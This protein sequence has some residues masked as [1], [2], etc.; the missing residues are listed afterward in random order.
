MS[1]FASR[2][3][4]TEHTAYAVTP[5][6]GGLLPSRAGLTGRPLGTATAAA[7]RRR[8]V[9]R[10]ATN[11]ATRREVRAP[12]PLPGGAGCQAAPGNGAAHTT[13]SGPLLRRGARRRPRRALGGLWRRLED[14]PVDVEPAGHAERH[15][16][17]HLRQRQPPP[18][19]GKRHCRTRGLKRE[20]P[21]P[22]R[23]PR[24][25]LRSPAGR[26]EKGR[27]QKVRR[28]PPRKRF[29]PRTRRPSP[30]GRQTTERRPPVR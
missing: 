1:I 5:S 28:S 23:A 9:P 14:G 11:A 26:G 22:L 8:E 17:R 20:A 21:R 27:G 25:H 18:H 7:R 12:F 19:G 16:Q 10:Q 24:R 13:P 2:Q 6:A 30:E 15:G 3:A 4:A 29:A